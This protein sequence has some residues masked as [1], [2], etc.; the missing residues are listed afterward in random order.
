MPG[1]RS[2]RRT[3]REED[4]AY[5][6]SLALARAIAERAG[7]EGLQA[8]WADAAGRR[9]G[10][11]AGRRRCRG[12]GRDPAGL[13]RAAGPARGADRRDVRRPV[14]GRGWRA[15]PTC[16]CSTRAPRRASATTTMVM[17]GR[18]L[19][20]ASPDPRRA[21]VVALQR[22]RGAP[23][24]R[25]GR[26]GRTRDGDRRPPRRP[27]SSRRPASGSPSRTTMASTTPTAETTAELDV[28]GRYVAATALRPDR[29]DA[30]HDPRPVGPDPGAGAGRGSRRLRDG[31]SRRVG[32]RVRMMSPRRGPTRSP[33]GQ[34]RAIS[35]GLIV[36]A[37]VFALAVVIETA[38][39]RRRRRR[40]CGWRPGIASN[41][42]H[43]ARSHR[44]H[45]RHVGHG[46]ASARTPATSMS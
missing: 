17:R 12:D 20:P 9:R 41:P 10:V 7:D 30:V 19:A 23:V 24:R 18:G 44:L 37:L 15:T 26:P 5:A 40:R 42:D 43:A 2:A 25:R 1:D 3:S 4:Y 13:A 32:G 35:I 27:A 22:R 39:R 46:G 16:R 14:A 34:N 28:I 21:A 29:D 11:P 6:A 45:S 8:V 36:L 33:L 38:R 31:R